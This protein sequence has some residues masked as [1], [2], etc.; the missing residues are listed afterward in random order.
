[1][2]K[3]DIPRNGRTGRDS[4]LSGIIIVRNM[5]SQF[6]LTPTHGN[7]IMHNGYAGQIESGLIIRGG[8]TK[9]NLPLAHILR[10][11]AIIGKF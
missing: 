3:R 7:A 6:S 11:G 1:M 5:L 10:G 8:R 4:I 2:R 9:S